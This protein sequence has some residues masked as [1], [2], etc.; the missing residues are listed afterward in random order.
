M[1]AALIQVNQTSL[2]GHLPHRVSLLRSAPR[3]SLARRQFLKVHDGGRIV[4][5]RRDHR[6]RRLTVGRR[7]IVGLGIG[8]SQ[9]EPFR[10]AFLKGAWSSAAFGRRVEPATPAGIHWVSARP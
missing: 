5:S 8:P 6:R 3:A 10:C 7:Q 1:L 2:R 4:P 9:A